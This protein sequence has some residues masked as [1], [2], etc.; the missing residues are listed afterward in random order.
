MPLRSMPGFGRSQLD[1]ADM[2][3]TWEVR[4]VNSRFLD[5]KW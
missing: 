1:D 5:L 3:Q 4:S 2:V